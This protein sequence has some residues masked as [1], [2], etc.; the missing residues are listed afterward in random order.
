MP[1]LPR[2]LVAASNI[3]VASKKSNRQVPSLINGDDK[4]QCFM[5]A[6]HFNLNRKTVIECGENSHEKWLVT[7]FSFDST[8]ETVCGDSMEFTSSRFPARTIFVAT[9]EMFAP[10]KLMSAV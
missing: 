3:N 8:G 4:E 7:F 6:T 2:K 5:M 1:R 9:A 10:C